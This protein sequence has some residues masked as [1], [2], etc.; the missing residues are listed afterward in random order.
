MSSRYIDNTFNSVGQAVVTSKDFNY[1]QFSAGRGIEMLVRSIFG[2][3]RDGTPINNPIV[4]WGCEITI[5]GS[6]TTISRGAIL[7]QNSPP[8]NSFGAGSASS[9]YDILLIENDQ[10]FTNPT[11]G[12]VVI[13]NIVPV[14][15][16]N[17]LFADSSTHPIYIFYKILFTTGVADSGTGP[18]YSE[19]VFITPTSN[20]A[21]GVI[22]GIT[23]GFT[24]DQNIV[25]DE[26]DNSGSGVNT[27]N[28]NSDFAREGIEVTIDALVNGTGL[29]VTFVQ[30]G[31]SSGNIRIIT[32][33]INLINTKRTLIKIKAVNCNILFGNINYLIEIYSYTP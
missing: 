8:G 9:Y 6:N 15:E 21:G 17:G 33:S 22:D 5:G 18:D 13:S 24:R 7:Y 16:G 29:H 12:N 14:N 30:T 31:S 19:L 25:K 2:S 26:Y 27:I 1:L 3:N 23:V 20:T 32:G 28:L 11:G 10:V 4:L